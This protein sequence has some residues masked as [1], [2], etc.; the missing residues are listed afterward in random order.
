MVRLA[1]PENRLGRL[2]LTACGLFLILAVLTACGGLAPKMITEEAMGPY[3]PGKAYLVVGQQIGPGNLT[4]MAAS[5][6]LDEDSLGAKGV[7]LPGAPD[8]DI[9]LGKGETRF[10][11]AG[12]D[13]RAYRV[14]VLDPKQFADGGRAFLFVNMVAA[15]EIAF[16]DRYPFAGLPCLTCGLMAPIDM[17]DPD[18]NYGE[19]FVGCPF[20]IEKPGVYYLGDLTVEA[21]LTRGDEGP[22]MD[23]SMSN[24][25]DP[26]R[27]RAYMESKGVN[28]ESF[29]DVSEAWRP[30]PLDSLGKYMGADPDL[31]YYR[32]Q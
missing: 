15:G 22:L 2:S 24:T 4:R 29:F 16:A 3:D 1:R 10:K 21:D 31:E 14:W 9:F 32:P 30:L 11:L 13:R 7:A 17:R 8:P 25:M 27:A 19:S 23:M 18:G 5:L 6:Y 12:E 20:L 28:T 26:A